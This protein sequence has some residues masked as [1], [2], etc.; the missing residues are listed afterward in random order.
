MK[1]DD[2]MGRQAKT[3]YSMRQQLLEGRY[4][5]EEVDEDGKPVGDVKTFEPRPSIIEEVLPRVTEVLG[6]F[7]ETPIRANPSTDG[8]KNGHGA[9]VPREAFETV[10]LV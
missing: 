10:K 3:V 8:A 4:Q 5:P 9:L 2:V 6:M 1:T 7:A